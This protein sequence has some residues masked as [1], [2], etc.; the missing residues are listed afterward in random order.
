VRAAVSHSSPKARAANSCRAH[1]VADA[2][3]DRLH[4]P[5]TPVC[6]EEVKRI[7]PL[8]GPVR[9][10]QPQPRFVTVA[11]GLLGERHEPQQAREAIRFL[12]RQRLVVLAP[13]GQGPG[14][15]HQLVDL[16]QREIPCTDDAID[17]SDGEPSP[18]GLHE[19]E[20]RL[21]GGLECALRLQPG[22]ISSFL[23]L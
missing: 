19:G 9:P 4:G 15:Q 1:A 16:S 20:S 12:G 18:Y 5:G 11:E 17:Q 22:R 8:K 13:M 7:P 10:P 23:R 6:V 21:R 2:A 14:G 3:E